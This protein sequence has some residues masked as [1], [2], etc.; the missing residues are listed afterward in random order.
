ML[1]ALNA[2]TFG[3]GEPNYCTFEGAQA[4]KKTIED[5]WRQLGTPVTIYVVESGFDLKTRATRFDLRSDMV[6][7][8][9][10]AV[11]R[12]EAA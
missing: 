7:G 4:L 10:R 8:Y 6:N 2:E 12:R 9:P 11:P 1:I 3:G 5:Y